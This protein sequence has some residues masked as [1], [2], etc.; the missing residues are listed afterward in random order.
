M[1][2]PLYSVV[3]DSTAKSCYK[4]LHPQLGTKDPSLQPFDLGL[5]FQKKAVGDH[6]Y[7]LNMVN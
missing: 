5:Q 2:S 3:I 7:T 4:P 1:V 6:I